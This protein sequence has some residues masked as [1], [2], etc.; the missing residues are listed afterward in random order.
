MAAPRQHALAPVLSLLLS[1]GIL[2]IGNGLQATLIAVRG[3]LEGLS[4]DQ[5]GF[6]QAGYF[7]GFVA[8]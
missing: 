6:V 4:A 3:G 8:G 1:V 5:L 2:L 7:M